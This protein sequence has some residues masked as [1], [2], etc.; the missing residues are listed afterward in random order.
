MSGQTPVEFRMLFPLA[1]VFAIMAISLIDIPQLASGAGREPASKAACCTSM[2]SGAAC[3]Q[4]LPSRLLALP[5]YSVKFAGIS[6]GAVDYDA[7]HFIVVMRCTFDDLSPEQSVVGM[8]EMGQ[9]EHAQTDVGTVVEGGSGFGAL[10]RDVQDFKKA[11]FQLHAS[12]PIATKS[13]STVKGAITVLRAS[14]RGALVWREP[15]GSEVGLTKRMGEFEITLSKCEIVNDLLTAE[16]ACKM[17]LDSAGK[18]GNW[19]QRQLKIGLMAADQTEIVA[20]SSKQTATAIRRVFMLNKKFPKALEM[21][22][23]TVLKLENLHFEL[24][25][26][27][28]DGSPLKKM[29]GTRGQDF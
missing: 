16:W 4:K 24:P 13:F 26:M 27:M 6:R 28:L 10:S 14:D 23:A 22:F 19:A 3:C 11:S 8:S 12:V 20:E 7:G 9:I 1:P 17:P 2:P 18:P 5:K 25:G 15:F 29:E 21:S